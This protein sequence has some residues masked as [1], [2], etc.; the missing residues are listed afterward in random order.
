M[1]DYYEQY[2][3]WIDWSVYDGLSEEEREKL[4]EKHIDQ[5]GLSQ[6]LKPDAPPEAYDAWRK[7]AIRTIQAKKEGEIVN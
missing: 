4:E 5:Y 6:V 2:Y 1:P 7:D 3:D